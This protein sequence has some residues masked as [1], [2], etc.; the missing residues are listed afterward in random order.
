MTYADEGK[1]RGFGMHAQLIDD[2][3]RKAAVT[4]RLTAVRLGDDVVTYGTLS[5]TIDAYD[6]VMRTN[7]LSG[8]AALYG[9]LM[10]SVPALVAIESDADRSN[11]LGE[12]VSW[13]GRDL[14]AQG[15]VRGGLRAVS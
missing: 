5:T 4:P 13:L 14:P 6:D 8:V 1:D 15:A 12:I 2:I 3:H 7:G 11:V 9:A 10:C